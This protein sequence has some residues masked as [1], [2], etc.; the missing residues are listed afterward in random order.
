MFNDSHAS[1]SQVAGITGV[2]HHAQLI[3][4]ILVRA[5]FCYV[6]QAGLELLASSDPPTLAYQNAKPLMFGS[7]E[8]PVVGLACVLQ[9]ACSNPGPTT[10]AVSTT[11]S[12]ECLQTP[13]H[14]CP[15]GA[16]LPLAKKLKTSLFLKKNV[17]L[18]LV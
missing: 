6:G 7:R 17:Y 5:V 15:L 9:D 14:A 8:S 10:D 3:F 1:A 16:E 12:S 18:F 2:Y 11:A 4:V 13:S